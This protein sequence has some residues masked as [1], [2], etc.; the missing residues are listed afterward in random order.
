M[1]THDLTHVTPS[2]F[3][4]AP[5]VSIE[6]PIREGKDSGR[7]AKD[8]V[9]WCFSF[10]SD[11]RNSP[12]ITNLRFWA[13]KAKLRLRADEETRVLSESRQLFSKRLEAMMKKSADPI[14]VPPSTEMPASVEVS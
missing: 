1:S 10:G 8:F 5:P 9:R 14:F 6:N 2:L 11:F 4:A 12:D 7:M 3:D 13:S